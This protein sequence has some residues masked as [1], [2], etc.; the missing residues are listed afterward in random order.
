MLENQAI[1]QTL[2]EK[3]LTTEVDFMRKIVK[4]KEEMDEK[5]RQM[6]KEN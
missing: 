3:G 1:V 2:I 4:F 5:V 6:G